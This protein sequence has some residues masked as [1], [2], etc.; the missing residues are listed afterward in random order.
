[1]KKFATSILLLI[2]FL[3]ST[4]F[5]VSV[6]YCMDVMKGVEIGVPGSDD[7]GNC[8]MVIKENNCCCKDEVKVVK[9]GVDQVV[10]KFV[11]ADFS[12][13]PLTVNHTKYLFPSIRNGAVA[14]E[15]VANAP[16]VSKPDIYLQ[17]G[18]F[19]I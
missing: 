1:M 17:I 9:I 8:G 13:S 3:V 11:K 7:C 15:P 12:L 4:G 16:P 18:V 6:H 5:V 19:R 2:Y 10:A 14:E